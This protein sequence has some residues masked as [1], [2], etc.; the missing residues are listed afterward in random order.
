MLGKHVFT[1]YKSVE[2][3]SVGRTIQHL[4]LEKQDHTD[5]GVS[6][7]IQLTH[8]GELYLE[9]GTEIEVEFRVLVRLAK[10]E[11]VR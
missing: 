3:E 7:V 4:K 5:D 11:K 2:S 10:E 1:V 8:L 9:V 6:G